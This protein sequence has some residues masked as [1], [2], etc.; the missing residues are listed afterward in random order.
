MLV[1]ILAALFAQPTLSHKVLILNDVHL[2][3][4]STEYYSTPG[5]E[6]NIRTLNLVLSEAKKVE[7]ASADPIEAIL[8]VG[9][10]NRHG[11]AS[12]DFDIPLKDTQWETM[13]TTMIEVITAIKDNFPAVPILPVIGNNDVIYHD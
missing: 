10:L 8:L 1:A 7:D 13:K 4:D 9:D 12:Y 6:C 2:D 3:I 11:L 5:E